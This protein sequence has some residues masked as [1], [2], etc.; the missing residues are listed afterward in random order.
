M[1]KKMAVVLG[2]VAI[3]SLTACG[4]TKGAVNYKKYMTLGEYKGIEYVKADTKVTD[5]EVQEQLD[6]FVASLASTE[7]V[8]RAA[9]DGDTVNIDYAGTIDD[10]AFDGGTAEA[11]DLVLGSGSFIEGFEEQLVGASAG[12]EVS[13]E[14]TFPE[15]YDSEDLAGKDAVF[16]VTVNKVSEPVEVELTDEVVAANSDYKTVDEYTEY[17]KDSLKTNKESS[18]E[19]TMQSDILKA[20]IDNSEFKSYPEEDKQALIDG[21]MSDTNDTAESYGVAVEDYI[22]Y[23][24]YSTMEDYEAA[25]AEYAES[26]LQEK[27]VINMIAIKEKIGVTSEEVT[28]Y[29]N[30]LVST[31]SLESTDDVYDYYSEEEIQYFVLA[32]KVMTFLTEN[33]VEVESTEAATEE[34]AKTTEAKDTEAK[35][36]EAKDTEETTEKTTE[37]A[38]T[39]A[40]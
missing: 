29:V 17:V 32:D 9:K 30:E 36:T 35:D 33:A 28:N 22:T 31:Y 10:V 34:E 40:E 20:I 18:A 8:D 37:E 4:S 14:V 23:V 39:E 5:D 15:D 26:Y 25:V 2:L 13:V 6:S 7:E 19:S 3:M 21:A 27:M 24:G 11:Y 38:T 16:A 12:D 1:K